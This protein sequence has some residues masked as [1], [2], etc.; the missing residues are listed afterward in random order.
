MFDL[1]DF[2]N[3]PQP[4]TS[5]ELA[6]VKEVKKHAVKHKRSLGLPDILEN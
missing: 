1:E 2:T 6:E 3:P 4:M 5:P